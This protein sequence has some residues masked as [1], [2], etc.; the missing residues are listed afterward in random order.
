VSCQIAIVLARSPGTAQYYFSVKLARETH[1]NARN[2][3]F[4]RELSPMKV[5]YDGTLMIYWQRTCPRIDS[6]NYELLA[7][8]AR[9]PLGFHR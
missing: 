4:C 5:Q 7:G 6:R 2:E 9:R 3:L 8:D 1:Q